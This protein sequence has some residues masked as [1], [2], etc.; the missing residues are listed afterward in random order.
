MYTIARASSFASLPA[1]SGTLSYPYHH[2]PPSFGPSNHS[3]SA[4]STPS[5]QLPPPLVANPNP[6]I[7]EA[8]PPAP[9]ASQPNPP[10]TPARGCLKAPSKEFAIRSEP[11]EPE[12]Q[13]ISPT[14]GHH[15]PGSGTR[16][17]PN[18]KLE[19]LPSNAI[20]RIQLAEGVEPHAQ[21]GKSATNSGA[22]GKCKERVPTPY[23]KS[24]KTG[25]LSDGEE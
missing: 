12:I 17:R 2:Y 3:R 11:A 1:G 13:I 19:R 20:A 7:V 25:W 6:S 21:G 18:M 9:S 4:P 15:V 8:A 16:R 22:R 24:D 10:S 23:V 14:S 5:E